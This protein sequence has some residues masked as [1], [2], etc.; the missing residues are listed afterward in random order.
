MQATTNRY[1]VCIKYADG[2]L[3]VLEFKGRMAWC[4]KTAQKHLKDVTER[5]E[6]GYYPG[7]VYAVCT[8]D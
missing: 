8:L 1:N 7:A 6:R 4:I 2:K 3:T 5:I